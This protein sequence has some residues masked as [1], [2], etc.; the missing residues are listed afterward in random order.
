MPN[1]VYKNPPL[2]ELIAELRW[3]PAIKAI[4]AGSLHKSMFDSSGD[5]VQTHLAA[6]V[7][8]I[9]YARVERLLPPGF[10][11]PPTLPALRFRPTDVA[12]KSPLFQWGN[13]VFTINGL[14]PEYRSWADFAPIIQ[15]GADA[16][17][18]SYA[19]ANLPAPS[20]TTAV[21]R[22][23]D[24]FKP[25]LTD[26]VPPLEFLDK[27]FGVRVQLPPTLTDLAHENSAII[28]RLELA[29]PLQLG[30][31]T[32]S[33]SQ[34]TKDNEEVVL[35]DTTVTVQREIGSSVDD[36]V[37]V[38]TEARDVIHKVFRGLTLPLHARMEPM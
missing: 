36:A 13:G 34:G 37:A 10:P 14:P 22:Y 16:L 28:P 20:I 38:L 3:G 17:F 23:I 35:L 25:D 24:A 33:C 1:L 7:A 31:M 30:V 21:V 2:V 6:R 4:G 27:V 32:V 11:L 12:K 9:G 5:G 8:S 15:I 29:I 19:D 18:R 26:G